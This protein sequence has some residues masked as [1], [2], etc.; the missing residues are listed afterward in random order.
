MLRYAFEED[1][2]YNFT[3]IYSDNE[4]ESM[5]F[6]DELK[7]MQQHDK[8]KF[9]PVVTQDQNWPG[10]KRHIDADFLKEYLGDIS[11]SL[12]YISGP[13]LAVTSVADNLKNA[14]IPE[15]SIKTDSFSGY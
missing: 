13:P 8:F 11:G 10:E 14:G 9:I 4:V 5:P 7:Q 2:N 12:Y 3:L 6:L 15:D 1:K